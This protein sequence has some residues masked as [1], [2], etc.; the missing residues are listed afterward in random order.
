M[1]ASVSSPSV[2]A[3]ARALRSGDDPT[4]I[5]SELGHASAGSAYEK[6]RVPPTGE[7]TEDADA[8]ETWADLMAASGV[9]TFRGELRVA[10]FA[11]RAGDRNMTDFDSAAGISSAFPFPVSIMLPRLLASPS[12]ASSSS[13][14]SA[15]P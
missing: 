8:A 15:A 2:S 10:N 6:R 11:G 14:T 12:S 1:A 13:S 9:E 4:Q 5:V 3:F 7:R